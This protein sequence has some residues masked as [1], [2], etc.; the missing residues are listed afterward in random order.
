[1]YPS[2]GN[3]APRDISSRAAKRVC[4]EGRGV[5]PTGLGVYLDFED[6]IKRLG[7][8]TIE[9]KY[10][11]LFEM[12]ERITDENPYQVPMRIY[13]ATHYTMGGLWVDYNLMSTIPG[14]FVLGEANFSDHG[15]NRL[16]ASAL[17][18][19]LA[20]GYFVIPY[21]IGN[22]LAREKFTPVPGDHP[23][24]RAAEKALTERTRRLLS[25]QGKRTPTSFHR[26]LGKIMWEH[27]GMARDRKGLEQGLAMIPKL[28]EEF[29]KNLHVPGS[30]RGA[31]P[32]ARACGPRGRLPRARR[33]HVPRRPRAR[34]VLR[35]PLPHRAPDA[36]RRS[37][38]QRQGLRP[39]RRLGVSGRRQEARPERGALGLR[40]RG[41]C[42]AELQMKIT[43]K[44]WRQK[45]AK[46]KGGFV[47]YEAADINEEM[48]FLEMLDVVNEGLIGKGEDPIAFDHDCRE[49]ICG[50]CGVVVNGRPHG[51]RD[52]TTACQLHMRSFHDGDVLTIEP[53]RAAAFPV[54]K[55][56]VVDRGAFDRII[57]AGGFIS[58]PGAARPTATRSPS[59]RRTRTS[60]WTRPPASAAAP[61]WRPAPT[62]RRCSSW[63]PR[64]RS[65]RSCPRASPNGTTASR[66]MVAQMDAEGFGTCT[67]H[68]ECEAA[69]PKAIR[70]EFIAR[71]N[72]DFLR[73]ALTAGRRRGGATDGAGG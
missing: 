20:D 6:A 37:A 2:F 27:C 72:A 62:P 52:R 50:T 44:V 71:M 18:Q 8:N 16:G 39:R 63:A 11:N 12:Y 23:E 15:A 54:V 40:E 24:V 33:A 36:R 56:L 69:C 19:G 9:E 30:G 13:P 59:R 68:G 38:A 34:R 66:N 55:D 51:P 42:R 70:V 29:W 35:Q 45:D 31:Q 5:G 46:A 61:A 26:E 21:T 60:P 49:G 7:R 65:S 43:L 41:A 32:V 73:S 53:W 17:M 64:S 67:N 48:S 58:A 4:D 3:L 1:M 14:L 22:Y 10:G 57:A 47:T 25:I 28:R